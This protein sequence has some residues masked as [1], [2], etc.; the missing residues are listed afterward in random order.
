MPERSRAHRLEAMSVALASIVLG[1]LSDP[2][3][4]LA[5]RR[6]GQRGI[7]F[8]HRRSTSPFSAVETTKVAVELA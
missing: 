8:R 4:D 2:G 3:G 6:F 1:A 7:A 5:A